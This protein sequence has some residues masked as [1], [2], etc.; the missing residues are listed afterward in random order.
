MI[1]Y[2]AQYIVLAQVLGVICVTEDQKLASKFPTLT[3]S[4]QKFLD[5]PD[6]SSPA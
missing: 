2:D 3:Q 6:A 5:R 4:M 1:V